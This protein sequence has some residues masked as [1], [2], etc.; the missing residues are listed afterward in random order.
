MMICERNPDENKIEDKLKLIEENLNDSARRRA[1]ENFLPGAPFS[2][3]RAN[4]NPLLASRT[5]T[6]ERKPSSIQCSKQV[7]SRS[8][9]PGIV[10]QFRTPFINTLNLILNSL[11][12]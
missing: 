10:K 4:K 2:Q 5:A 8:G 6:K 12:F 7:K 3:H 9:N 1:N 11:H